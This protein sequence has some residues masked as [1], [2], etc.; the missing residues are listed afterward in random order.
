L[1]LTLAGID[2]LPVL[3]GLLFL[4]SACFG[5]VIPSTAVLALD[6][7]GP[8]AGMASALLGTLRLAAGAIMI[9]LVSVF[10]DGTTLPMVGAIAFCAAGALA[11]ARLTLSGREPAAAPAE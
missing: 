3:V 4:S 9:G 10:F 5:L 8:I 6:P 2:S 1:A 7:H 11:L